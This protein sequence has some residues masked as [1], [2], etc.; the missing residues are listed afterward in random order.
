MAYQRVPAR[1]SEDR[2][3]NPYDDG[4]Q[5]E[6]RHRRGDSFHAV[7][8]VIGTKAGTNATG[9]GILS[10]LKAGWSHGLSR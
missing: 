5:N 9:V 10:F 4:G 1:E 8:P 2:N 6:K 7:K 3:R